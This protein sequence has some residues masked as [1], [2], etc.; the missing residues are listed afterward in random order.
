MTICIRS[1]LRYI[2]VFIKSKFQF[3][4]PETSDIIKDSDWSFCFPLRVVCSQVGSPH[5]SKLAASNLQISTLPHSGSEE[6]ESVSLLDKLKSHAHV[7][8]QESGN[9]KIDLA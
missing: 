3:K 9:T 2:K 4:E 5:G 7:C 1:F 8:C 6:R